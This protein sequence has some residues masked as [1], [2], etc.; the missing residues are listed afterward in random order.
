MESTLVEALGLT[1]SPVAVVLTDSKPDGALQFREGRWG[2]VGSMLVSASKGRSAIFDRQSF[3]CPGG[4]TGLGFGNQYEQQGFAIDRLLACGS[5]EIAAKMQ[6]KSHWEEGERFFK[7]PELAGAA[8]ASLPMTDVP[9]EY[10]V[11]KPL[12]LAEQDEPT[13]VVFFVTP[14]QLSALVVLSGFDRGT[15]EGAI[16]PFGAACHSILWAYAE[17]RR[18]EPRGV[19]GFFD[20]AV[21]SQV[22]RDTLTF[23][24]PYAMYRRME[25]NVAGSFLELDDWLE[26]RGRQ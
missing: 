20:I 5:S 1:S 19:I 9:T 16:A 17:A 21:R 25:G 8:I 13:L 15:N 7:S 22:P 24:V 10:V 26:L 6:R 2:C 18:D 14:D 12:E 3:G 4:G 23:T 11:F